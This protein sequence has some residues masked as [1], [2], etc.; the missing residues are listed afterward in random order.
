MT[1][2]LV[3]ANNSVTFSVASSL[4]PFTAVLNSIIPNADIDGSRRSKGK[5]EEEEQDGD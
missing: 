2:S 1:S 4:L 3:Q 5:K